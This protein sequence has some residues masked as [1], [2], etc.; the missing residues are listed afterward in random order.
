MYRCPANTGCQFLES[1]PPA[2]SD[3]KYTEIVL[4]MFDRS[5]VRH[6]DK[7]KAPTLIAVGTRDLR[8]PLSQGKLWYNRLIANNVKTRYVS[9]LVTKYPK[10]I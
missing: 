5:P 4:K 9:F 10:F 8:S 1:L 2:S 6:A 3:T 7:V